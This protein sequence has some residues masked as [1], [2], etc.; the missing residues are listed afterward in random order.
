MTE[1]LTLDKDNPLATK[2]QT[3][4]GRKARLICVD[5]P[6]EQPIIAI[7]ADVDG[8][9]DRVEYFWRDGGW[10][11][12]RGSF[13]HADLVNVPVEREY[14]KAIEYS[15]DGPTWPAPSVVSQIIGIVQD[16]NKYGFNGGIDE[17]CAWLKAQ[18][19]DD[20]HYAAKRIEGMKR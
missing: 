10:T 3:R 9:N 1:K 18:P 20:F 12:I 7:V 16:A 13:T 6:G 11:L 14:A 17:A 8:V 15:E 4:D 5:G 2:V 19:G